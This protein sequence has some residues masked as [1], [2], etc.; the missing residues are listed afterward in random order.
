MSLLL[1]LVDE[2]LLAHPLRISGREGG[3]RADP[4]V[5]GGRQ[6]RRRRGHEAF[7]R[8]GVAPLR[9]L[10]LDQ[11]DGR[12]PEGLRQRYE[13]GAALRHSARLE[14]YVAVNPAQ[15]LA[16]LEE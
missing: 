3:Y 7:A 8:V 16:P 13:H 10:S 9:V 1:Q 4:G 14:Q 15:L 11:S 5:G 2:G 6:P 12:L